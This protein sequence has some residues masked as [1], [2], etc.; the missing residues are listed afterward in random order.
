MNAAAY[1]KYL[2]LGGKKVEEDD[3]FKAA[4]RLVESFGISAEDFCHWAL[5]V[6]MDDDLNFGSINSACDFLAAASGHEDSPAVKA[7]ARWKT[8]QEIL[9]RNFSSTDSL[10]RNLYGCRGRMCSVKTEK[11]I[12]ESARKAMKIDEILKW[13]ERNPILNLL[14]NRS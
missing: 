6:C 4:S 2:S 11:E 1:R 3:A 7:F 9:S 13:L 5:A 8:V 14:R 12:R 10:A